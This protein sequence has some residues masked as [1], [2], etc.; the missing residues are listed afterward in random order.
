[1]KIKLSCVIILF[2]ILYGEP[3]FGL[4]QG[5]KFS[6][7]SS[8]MEPNL[9]VHNE[10]LI[11]VNNTV[12]SVMDV[13]KEM[14]MI[15]MNSYPNL[16]DSKQAKHQFYTSSWK[17]V[18]TQ[19]ISKELM[20][21]DAEGKVEVSE[22]EVREE[23]ER[24][25]APNIMMA[26][27]KIGM[28]LDEAKE[29]IKKEIIFQRMSWYFIHNQATQAVTPQDIRKAYENYLRNNPAKTEW[30]YQVITIR[31]DDPSKTE[32]LSNKISRL[33]EDKTKDFSN[34]TSEILAL[35]EEKGVIKISDELV[36]NSQ[37]IS[38]NHKKALELL[39]EKEHSLPIKQTDT[40]N[41]KSTYRIFYVKNIQKKEPESFQAMTKELK[42]HLV[43]EQSAIEGEKYITKLKKQYGME[44]QQLLVPD[45]FNPFTLK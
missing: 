3:N 8:S 22:G 16:A 5:Q 28:P 19:M 21:L 6:T 41:Q 42:N 17:Q 39:G 1:M 10:V 36:N 14:D 4:G 18:L 44:N 32:D 38:E 24:R 31:G 27:D 20:I 45:D 40:N 25:F 9:T 43:Q 33:L 15:F 35:E 30:T 26:L 12:I 2:S 7:P 13:L 23:L 11:K 34:I 37:D 29:K